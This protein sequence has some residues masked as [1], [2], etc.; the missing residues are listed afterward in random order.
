MAIAVL[1]LPVPARSVDTLGVKELYALKHETTNRALNAKMLCS[2]HARPPTLAVQ[3]RGRGEG[4][5]VQ[6]VACM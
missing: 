1:T 6:A 2:L 3:V 4:L 5:C